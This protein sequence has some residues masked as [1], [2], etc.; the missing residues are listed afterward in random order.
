MYQQN[1]KKMFGFVDDQLG[2]EKTT[3]IL[4]QLGQLTSH[5][6][7]EEEINVDFGLRML[8]KEPV[9][10]SKDDLLDQLV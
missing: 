7:Q 5:E 9:V 2:P 1:V 6:R 10:I 3:M 8:I 4:D